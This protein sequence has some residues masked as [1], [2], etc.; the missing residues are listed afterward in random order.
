MYV[1]MYASS[2][3][4][5]TRRN[6]VRPLELCTTKKPSPTWNNQLRTTAVDGG[7]PATYCISSSIYTTTDYDMDLYSAWLPTL[8]SS[9][10]LLSY[11][12]TLSTI[13]YAAP[14][15]IEVLTHW[16]KVGPYPQIR[17]TCNCT[18][19]IIRQSHRLANRNSI[20]T[21]PRVHGSTTTTSIWK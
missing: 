21:G 7:C 5:E 3:Q 14:S 16:H 13:T 2:L 11:I 17:D 15:D 10:S 9:Q 12:H 4:V 19:F 1:C 20:T 6:R 18:P 8:Y